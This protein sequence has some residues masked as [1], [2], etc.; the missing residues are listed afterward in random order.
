VSSKSPR[1]EPP[2][3]R[4]ELG[5]A[6]APVRTL[7]IPRRAWS[8]CAL[9]ATALFTLSGQPAQA[10]GAPALPSSGLV[11]SDPVGAP[12][13]SEL[14][15]LGESIARGE[16]PALSQKAQ[17]VSPSAT[18]A[19]TPWGVYYVHFKDLAG[20]GGGP[21]GPDTNQWT[22]ILSLRSNGTAELYA[23]IDMSQYPG[24]GTT[25]C[26]SRSIEDVGPNLT[27]TWSVNGSTLTIEGPGYSWQ[28]DNCEPGWHIYKPFPKLRESFTYQFYA[29]FAAVKLTSLDPQFFPPQEGKTFI[30]QK[31]SSYSPNPT[32]KDFNGNGNDDLVWEN[33][34]TGERA[35]WFLHNGVVSS[36]SS[37]PTVPVQWHIA[38]VGDIKGDGN[39]DLVFENTSTGERAIWFLQNGVV[40]S[41]TYL[42]TVPVEWH[43]VGV[44]NFKGG[45]AGL[46]WENTNTGER[47][48]WFLQNG[49][50][51]S[52]IYLPTMPVQWHIAG[53]G[54]FNGDGNDDLVW[55]DTITGQRAIWFFKNGALSSTTFL[56]TIPAEWHIA[57]AGNFS[58]N[59]Y[60]GLVWQNSRTG[61]RAIWSMKNGVLISTI[62]LPTMPL[63]W[64][65]VD[66]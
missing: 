11:S 37:L 45:G 8:A 13:A 62:N 31:I 49:V 30:F 41:K 29:G 3:R 40:T 4:A 35:I 21:N 6:L 23:E 19:N 44:G 1:N 54:D 32:A 2:Q 56:P 14:R 48:I 36:T 53:V 27:A 5:W 61:E 33:T 16:S 39:A 47:A 10:Q 63:N 38:G 24:Y 34:R 20:T 15:Q 55:E 43:I 57:G 66:H 42:P 9:V 17:G 50:F 12:A 28:D 58:G 59:G 64:S 65:I 26:V 7:L 18:F 52:S 22:Y 60:A 25:N 51:S 46:V